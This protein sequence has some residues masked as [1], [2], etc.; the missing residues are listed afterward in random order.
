M[1]KKYSPQAAIRA[2]HAKKRILQNAQCVSD[3]F[4]IRYL[5]TK[6]RRVLAV[7][8]SVT[9]KWECPSQNRD[10]LCHRVGSVYLFLPY[11]LAVSPAWNP[12]VEGSN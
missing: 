9:G 7:L 12:N 8:N 11:H 6:S 1:S 3:N 5:I 10:I 4:G 2:R